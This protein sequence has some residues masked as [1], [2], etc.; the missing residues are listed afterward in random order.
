M[1]T[2]R[3]PL[4]NLQRFTVTCRSSES[5]E[6]FTWEVFQGAANI[7]L[8]ICVVSV[9]C[10]VGEKANS[11][12]KQTSVSSNQIAIDQRAAS[13]QPTIKVATRR[14]SV[15][16]DEAQSLIVTVSNIGSGA[17]KD[18]VILAR[19][20]E[21]FLQETIQN[22]FEPGVLPVMRKPLVP[23]IPRSKATE[24][25]IHAFLRAPVLPEHSYGQDF[26]EPGQ[27]LEFQYGCFPYGQ[28]PASLSITL[29]ISFYDIDDHE[30][31][32]IVKQVPGFALPPTLLPSKI[33]IFDTLSR[34]ATDIGFYQYRV[35]RAPHLREVG[36]L[37][38]EQASSPKE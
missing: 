4:R 3:R 32:T 5:R 17:A 37:F 2:N 38:R 23:N 15:G 33:A 21:S 9:T 35:L 30:Y 12:L 20:Q 6:R 25:V 8:A 10:Y 1:R 36:G 7:L 26:I 14:V 27:K 11:I 34:L 31:L 19:D 28:M 22:L 16:D 24:P 18:I 29:F 13:I